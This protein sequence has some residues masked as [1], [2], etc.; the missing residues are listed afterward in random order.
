MLVLLLMMMMPNYVLT[1]SS[2]PSISS[3]S[4]LSLSGSLSSQGQHVAPN[5]ITHL[6]LLSSSGLWLSDLSST[7]SYEAQ[8]QPAQAGLSLGILLFFLIVQVRLNVANGLLDE[9]IVKQEAV[10]RLSQELD[11]KQLSGRAAPI[12]EEKLR[13]AR[14]ELKSL[15]DRQQSL[16]TFLSFGETTIRFRAPRST[17]KE[18]EEK[19]RL[20]PDSMFFSDDE[21]EIARKKSTKELIVVSLSAL[22]VVALVSVLTLLAKDPISTERMEQISRYIEEHG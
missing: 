9:I 13:N 5:F 7:V 4:S 3:L 21:E 10:K 1:W 12:D 18:T 19:T 22:A 16:R 8:I 20:S 11:V 17:T 2:I 15:E 6:D 14:N